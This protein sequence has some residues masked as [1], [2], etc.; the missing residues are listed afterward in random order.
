MLLMQPEDFRA[1]VNVFAGRCWP[2]WWRSAAWSPLQEVTE[3]LSHTLNVAPGRCGI[4][5]TLPAEFGVKVSAA[6]PAD[7]L[8]ISAYLPPLRN[9]AIK[10]LL[11]LTPLR[12]SLGIGRWEPRHE[13]LSPPHSRWERAAFV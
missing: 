10:R 1:A 4:K 12:H 3:K 7:P 13:T 2:S 11:K 6:Q 9:C 5:V 8:G